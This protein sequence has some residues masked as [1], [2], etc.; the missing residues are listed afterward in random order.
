MELNRARA[1]GID[2]QTGI[3]ANGGNGRAFERD[4]IGAQS[5]TRSSLVDGEQ[6]RGR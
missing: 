5:G 1:V 4:V 2:E 6:R 3:G